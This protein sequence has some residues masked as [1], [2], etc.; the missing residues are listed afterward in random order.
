MAGRDRRS[1]PSFRGLQPASTAAR[2][3]SGKIIRAA[4]SP[5]GASFGVAAFATDSI[6]PSCR[7]VQTSCSPAIAS[8][9]FLTAT[10]G[11]DPVLST[12]SI[13]TAKLNE[14]DLATYRLTAVPAADCGEVLF[15][16]EL[17]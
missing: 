8:S 7:V 11:T 6:L 12:C 5:F 15:P 13:E 1:L 3:A 2:G 14:I 9:F 16:W 10:S 17:R 4:S